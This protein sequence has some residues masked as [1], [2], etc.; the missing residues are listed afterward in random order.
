MQAASSPKHRGST[1]V[2][3]SMAG[4]QS[5]PRPWVN[6]L[7]FGVVILLGTWIVHQTE[8]AIEY[9]RRFSEVMAT[10]SH[11]LYMAPAG[12]ALALALGA[13]LVLYS[14]LLGI[15]RIRLRRLLLR[16]PPRLIRHVHLIDSTVSWRAIGTTT[17]ALASAQIVVYVLQENLEYL[18]TA[19]TLPGL[20]VLLAPHHVTVVPLHLI[21]A[22]C[23]SV[24]LWTISARLGS[25]RHALGMAT[26][27]LAIA[28]GGDCPAP[29]RFLS[30]NNVPSL[31]F[32][33]GIFCLRS[34]PLYA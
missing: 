8:Y 18:A 26:V 9:G 13:I 28:T 5:Y 4:W 33:E 19:G 3:P 10:S 15:S 23:G 29:R 12:I 17:L 2:V 14:S 16:L 7:I 1:T 30:Q 22:M 11:R 27:L 32:A 34:P 21:V 25:N 24:L 31:R 20:S 6:L